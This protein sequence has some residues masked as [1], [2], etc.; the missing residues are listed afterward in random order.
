M[1]FQEF[2]RIRSLITVSYLVIAGNSGIRKE[3][4]GYAYDHHAKI[5]NLIVKEILQW[6]HHLVLENDANEIAVELQDI[7]S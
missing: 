4:L 3:Y 1:E 7:C 5:G 6:D 2:C